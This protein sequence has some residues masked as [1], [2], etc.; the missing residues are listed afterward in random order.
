MTD[1]QEG[2]L[3]IHQVRLL[4]SLTGYIGS[5]PRTA[6]GRQD[7]SESIFEN[8]MVGRDFKW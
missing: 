6:G 4:F 1:G 3:Y 7:I 5:E 2:E 8:H